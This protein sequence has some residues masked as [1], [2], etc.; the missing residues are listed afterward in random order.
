M[1]PLDRAFDLQLYALLLRT[2]MQQQQ[3]HSPLPLLALLG[4][5]LLQS[6]SASGATNAGAA[7]AG[8]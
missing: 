7:S 1:D 2:V 6:A 3:Q 5:S 4:C 8:C